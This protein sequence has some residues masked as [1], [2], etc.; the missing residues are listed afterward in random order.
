M[1][2]PKRQAATP[3]TIQRGGTVKR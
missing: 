2:R 1:T 3:R